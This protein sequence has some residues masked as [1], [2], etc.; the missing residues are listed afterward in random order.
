MPSKN[1]RPSASCFLSREGAFI[2]Y[3]KPNYDD[4]GDGDLR[5]ME[6]ATLVRIT[7][8]IA[9]ILTG[10]AFPKMVAGLCAGALWVAFSMVG[11]FL[12]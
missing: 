7:L 3:G 8:I 4:D 10:A 11:S 1:K 6:R 9:F 12:P 5:R 2:V